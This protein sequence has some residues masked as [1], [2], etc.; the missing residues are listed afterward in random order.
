MPSDMQPI[1][2][3]STSLSCSGI[4][5][6]LSSLYSVWLMPGKEQFHSCRITLKNLSLFSMV[7]LIKL[8]YFLQVKL[9]NRDILLPPG[10]ISK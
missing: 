9:I 10:K 1:A 6:D 4:I 7:H 5:Y 2:S 3:H 8:S